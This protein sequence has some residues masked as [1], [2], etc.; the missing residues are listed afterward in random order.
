MQSGV[1]SYHS[2]SVQ[3]LT[4]DPQPSAINTGYPPTQT[5][6]YSKSEI[7]EQFREINQ[8]FNQLNLQ[9]QADQQQQQ[10]QPI[11]LDYSAPAMNP[12]VPDYQS[13]QLGDPY[14]NQYPSMPYGGS[15]GGIDQG[16]PV[17]SMDSPNYY[18]PSQF[19]SVAQHNVDNTS[20]YDYYGQSQSNTEV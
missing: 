19:G 20:N 11:S 13:Q 4:Q 6:D 12:P 3:N 9:Y 14:Q 7:D 15:G 10:N 1:L 8:Q 5:V 16:N 2:S 17:T 18:D